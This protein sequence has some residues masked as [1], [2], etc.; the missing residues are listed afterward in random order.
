LKFKSEQKNNY[1][2]LIW[3]S[4][5]IAISLVV[6]LF[7]F[8][9]FFYTED[10][11]VFD[12]ISLMFYIAIP[13]SLVIISIWTIRFK[14][15]QGI[16]IKSRIFLSASFVSWFLAEQIWML[17]QYVFD[18]YPFPSI[19]DIFYLS[20][21]ILML[22]SFMIFLKPLKKEITKKNIIIAT[23]CSLLLLIPTVIITYSENSDLE[24]LE[25][26]IVLMHPISDA[27]LIIPI[28]IISL[29]LVQTKKNPFWKMI[30]LGAIIFISAD[31]WYLFLEINEE[32]VHN[33]PVDMLWLLS[34]LFWSFSLIQVI[35][36]SKKYSKNETE[37]K[38][39]AKNEIQSFNRYGIVSFLII[40]N[41]T[42]IGVLFSINYLI[43]YQ[44]NSEFLK[45]FSAFLVGIMIIFSSL[46]IL[47]NKSMQTKLE[48]Q[49]SQ[50][51]E[52][53]KEF[54]KS[55]KLSAI[56]QLS[57]RMAHDIRNPLTVIRLCLENM[58][59]QYDTNETQERS[60][61][62][63]ERSIDR[64]AHQIEDVL[65]YVKGVPVKLHTEK[66]SEIL[67][68]A[69]D[70]LIISEKITVILPKNDVKIICDK[71]QFVVMMNNLILNGIQAINGSGVIEITCEKKK[72]ITQIQIIDSGIGISQENL[73]KIFE[74]LYTTKFS[75]TGLGLA[76]VKS[77]MKSH[78]GI[79]SVTSPPT[80]F[81]ITLP[82]D[83]K[84]ELMDKNLLH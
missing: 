6:I 64:I 79:I 20:A 81:T 55:E 46:I 73:E 52:I 57:S 31:T 59:I 5:F 37:Y 38:K 33:H 58:K 7:Y 32:Y 53:S 67:N 77:I 48:K 78:G 28:I 56:G 9:N 42:V 44:N 40:I 51:E 74:P 82:N 18:V 62:K 41:I 39:Y 83:L 34:Y 60:F 12:N 43:P 16:P 70:S 84:S 25:S 4:S 80:T 66:F 8:I 3:Y 71:K 72:D 69:I 15:I 19:A 50:L 11:A 49:D 35:Y 21:P 75:G 17:Y 68:E 61:Q 63:I 14:Q 54:I 22:T 1:F 65:G 23:C 10:F 2:D 30:L 45:F 27:L 76:G 36:K 47:L 24:L 13:G 26:F 29:F